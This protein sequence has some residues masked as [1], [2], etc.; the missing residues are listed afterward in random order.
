MQGDVKELGVSFRI[1]A[2]LVAHS[3]AHAGTAGIGAVIAGFGGTIQFPI[4]IHETAAP[5]ELTLATT[6]STGRNI[7]DATAAYVG[8]V[9]VQALAD[10]GLTNWDAESEAW[11]WDARPGL[12]LHGQCMDPCSGYAYG[13]YGWMMP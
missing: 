9:W 3:Q 12:D 7:T 8:S 13:V 5:K 1:G 6:V 4:F 10:A 2:A 11:V